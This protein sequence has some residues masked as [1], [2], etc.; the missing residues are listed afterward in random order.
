M[1]NFDYLLFMKHQR[2]HIGHNAWDWQLL[3]TTYHGTNTT[4][5]AGVW[6]VDSA[7]VRAAQPATSSSAQGAGACTLPHLALPGTAWS[8]ASRSEE[9]KSRVLKCAHFIKP[10]LGR[11]FHKGVFIGACVHGSGEVCEVLSVL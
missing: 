9:G 1:Q 3:V 2:Q 7:D 4:P 8:P 10:E 11:G 6:S 5:L